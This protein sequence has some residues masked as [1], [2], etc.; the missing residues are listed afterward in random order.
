MRE[1]SQEEQAKVTHYR[2]LLYTSQAETDPQTG[3]TRLVS[4]PT[5]MRQAYEAAR[6]AY[7][8]AEQAYQARRLEANTSADPR[9]VLD[10]GVNAA[11]YR[12]QVQAALHAWVSGGYKNEVEQ[13]EAYLAQVTGCPPDTDLPGP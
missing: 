8:A 11:G 1:L 13:M 9:A 2:S 12:R 3:A 5:P 10:F 7:A 6:Q 4:V